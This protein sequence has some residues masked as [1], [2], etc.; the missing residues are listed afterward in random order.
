MNKFDIVY[1]HMIMQRTEELGIPAYSL[2][3]EIEPFYVASILDFF[4]IIVNY[5]KMKEYASDDI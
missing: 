3:K 1:E 2:V 4:S 5:V